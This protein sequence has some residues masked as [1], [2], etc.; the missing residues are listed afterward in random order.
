M[1]T[2]C[3]SATKAWCVWGSSLYELLWKPK[4]WTKTNLTEKC[5]EVIRSDNVNELTALQSMGGKQ[6]VLRAH[7]DAI[8]VLMKTVTS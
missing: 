1:R 5:N 8:L 3:V 6:R 2:L 7:S 4:T